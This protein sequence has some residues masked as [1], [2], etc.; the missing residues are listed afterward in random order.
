MP[1]NSGN[2]ERT[3]EQNNQAVKGVNTPTIDGTD[4]IR[5]VQSANQEDTNGE[6]VSSVQLSKSEKSAKCPNYAEGLAGH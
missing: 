2:S 6:S 4:S 5:N 3:E 1:R